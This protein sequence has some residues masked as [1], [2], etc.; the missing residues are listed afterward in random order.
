[1]I[2]I[3]YGKAKSGKTHQIYSEI[4]EAAQ[5]ASQKG[6]LYLIVPE[7]YTLEAEKQLIEHG[8]SDGFVGIEVVSFKR[9]AHK[10][11]SE[12]C[13]PEGVRI[14]EIGKI[15]MLRRL[16]STSKSDLTVYQ[17]AYNKL[18]FLS[19]FHDLIKEFKQNM[20]TPEALDQM[21]GVVEDATLLKNKLKDF[22]VVYK[23]YENEK[24]K[25]YFDDEDFYMTLLEILPKSQNLKHAMIW[26][27]GFDSFTV[28]ELQ[29]LSIL[30][31]LA[32]T[33]NIAICTDGVMKEGHFDHTNA[34][35]KR[36][37]EMARENGIA[38]T[39]ELCERPF[40]SHDI[41]HI[42]ENLLAYPYTKKAIS[43]DAVQ[44]FVA[45]NRLDEV[46]YCAA[47]IVD[48][49]RHEGYDWQDFAVVTNDLDAYAMSIKRMFDEF[50]LPYFLDQKRQVANNP[51][52]HLIK[53][54]LHMY[55]EGFS[56]EQMVNFLKT[57]LVESDVLAISRFEIY[58][59]QYGVREKKLMRPFEIEGQ[60]LTLENAVRETLASLIVPDFKSKITVRTAI[61]KLFELLIKLGV[62]EKI[63]AQVKAFTAAGNYDEAQH[64]AQIWNKTM[65]L[66]DQLVEIMGDE[67]VT[68][69]A[70]VEV[71]E[72]GFDTTEVGLLPLS[73]SQILVGSID[74]SR[75]H[76]IKVLFFLGLNDGIVP[77]L[78][79]DKQ[80]ILDSEKAFFSEKGIKLLADSQMFVSKE[81]FNLYFAMTRPTEKLYFSY[82]RSDSEGRAL[83]PSYFINKLS[84]ICSN[85]KTIDARITHD[86]LPYRVSTSKGTVKHLATE[87][88]RAVDGYPVSP[89][90]EAAFAWYAEN[91]RQTANLLIHGL[92]HSNIVDKLS[93]KA[94][95]A[96]YDLPIKTSVSRLERF[97][98]CPFKY[99]VESG[100]KPI[101]Q[102]SYEL[103]APDVGILF[104]SALEHFGKT[105]FNENID[106]KTLSK[107]RSDAMMESIINT[108]TDVDI[109]Q[110]RFQY[111]YMINK[112]KRVSKK[113]AWTL[114]QQL[115]SGA[116]VP[117]AF[118]VAF[119]DGP[120]SV[121][122]ILVS[123]TNGESLLIRGVIDRVD[124][125]EI[126][127]KKYIKI[128]DYKS[129]R[130][131]LSLSDI[132]N[133][134]QMQLMVYLSACMDNPHYFKATEI[135][136]AGAFYFRIDDPFI[137][138]TTQVEAIVH[139][140]IASELKLDGISLEDVK[141]LKHLDADLFDHNV[142]NV[143]Q[144]K[145]KSDGAF[146]KDSKIMP[147]EAF[148]GMI[149]HVEE[150]I[151]TIGDELLEGKIDV[152]P[153]KTD[154]FVSCQYCDFKSL[155][156]FD[157]H[158][159]GN[160]YRTIKSL[161]NEEV[162]E[163]LKG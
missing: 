62:N 153:C 76:P 11:F 14:S 9:L 74:R 28:Q 91:E 16:F 64:F 24:A 159:K 41:L 57:G 93:Q 90:W 88:R 138:A 80:L 147:I 50:E 35:F 112:L 37:S 7:Q 102:K 6:L 161:S 8:K 56:T 95:L 36:F 70:L 18:G 154:G 125:V 82:A 97:V 148:E 54:Y 85:I 61:E 117:T 73:D 83:R 128:I 23:A 123:L 46:E 3:V 45:D 40:P 116:F 113:A 69:E 124:T 120:E 81:Q 158:F 75:A 118:E 136:P 10:V 79:N 151:R 105:I 131:S 99:F 72:S 12:I 22:S 77:E 32:T 48:L 43:E 89:E 51:L 65:D 31:S 149:K 63:E 157:R 122:P 115:S 71:V 133:G 94:V 126:D 137:E 27:D 129:G 67:V 100:L 34:L 134:L 5:K 26:I 49:V 101:P 87:M 96:A 53:S 111:Q 42:A 142:S 109:Y 29:I 21:I 143:I 114:T 68:I 130:K 2:R 160:A 52:V 121:A 107:E 108:I 92:T 155:C 106:W 152:S 1:M 47:K 103:G 156:Q 84:R 139:D 145:I 59:K 135:A 38:L 66:F 78:G 119:G 60:D 15:M 13:Q 44:I 163:K 162:I 30:S 110:S 146:S 25:D 140:K 19:K 98:E 20:V 127:G 104:H 141:V 132:Y 33:L 4:H 58:A 17:S 55:S 150:T 39:A 86:V 144:V